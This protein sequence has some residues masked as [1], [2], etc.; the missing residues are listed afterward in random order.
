MTTTAA[1]V[2]TMTSSRVHRRSPLR[3]TSGPERILTAGLATATCV[4]LVGLIGVRTIEANPV[5][6][7]TPATPEP[8]AASATL[9]PVAAPATAPATSSAG[10]TEA[11]LDAYAA[12]LATERQRLDDYRAK[13][14]R[15]AKAL[16]RQIVRLNAGAVS[17]GAPSTSPSWSGS[18][19]PAASTSNSGGGGGATASKPSKPSKPKGGSSGSG[20]A[21]AAAPDAPAAPAPAPQKPAPKP[22]AAPA[23]QQAASGSGGSGGSSGG[24][25]GQSTTKSS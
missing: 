17:A 6:A 11:Q 7:E 13:L 21:A 10:L 14:T 3:R 5:A 4:G 9:T 18:S 22:V 24:G 2:M 20:S 15:T 8:Q 16:K 1:T 12:Q 19:A 23:Q 25:S